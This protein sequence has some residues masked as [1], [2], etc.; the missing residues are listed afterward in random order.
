MLGEQQRV[1][2]SGIFPVKLRELVGLAYTWDSASGPLYFNPFVLHEFNTF[3]AVFNI[4]S[5]LNHG[6]SKY[7]S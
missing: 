2:E 7:Y 5:Q 6:V 3:H 1:N 4:F